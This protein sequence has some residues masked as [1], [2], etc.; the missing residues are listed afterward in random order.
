M[1]LVATSRLSV[2]VRRR[3]SSSGLSLHDAC[4]NPA[5]F[6]LE[7]SDGFKAALLHAGSARGLVNGWAYA[8]KLPTGDLQATGLTSTGATTRRGGPARGPPYP[9]FSYLS[10][11]VQEMFLTGKAQCEP[12]FLLVFYYYACTEP[13]CWV[14]LRCIYCACGY[15]RY[16]AE[17]TLLVT[18]QIPAIE[19]R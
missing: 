10:L 7:Y 4:A 6:L 14:D 16:P 9:H 3:E 5:L 2:L 18:G 8:A 15:D 11:N 1:L 12:C 17:R 19:T 13:F